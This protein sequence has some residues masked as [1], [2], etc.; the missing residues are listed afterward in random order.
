[1]EAR[2]P[3]LRRKEMQSNSLRLSLSNSCSTETAFQQDRE[4]I[5]RRQKNDLEFEPV[6]RLIEI[7]D[8]VDQ[9]IRELRQEHPKPSR[10]ERQ[11][12]EQLEVERDRI[13]AE[14]M[15]IGKEGTINHNG[16]TITD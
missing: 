16:Q 5:K 9:D 4:A 8:A 13:Q 15:L 14:I 3:T 7:R 2:L 10:F 11:R 12:I 6:K 1:M